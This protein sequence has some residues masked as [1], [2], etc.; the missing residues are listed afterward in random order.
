[1]LWRHGGV[2]SSY[3]APPDP[4]KEQEHYD[5]VLTPVIMAPRKSC[6]FMCPSPPRGRGRMIRP[7]QTTIIGNNMSIKTRHGGREGGSFFHT[8]PYDDISLY[9]PHPSI[10][11]S[12][13]G[14][15]CA[16]RQ[17][18]VD[19]FL[20]SESGEFVDVA[21]LGILTQLTSGTG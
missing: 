4:P 15:Q 5:Y 12:R 19:V 20:A 10:H 21:T 14:D 1:M 7:S 9:H 6:P 11:R 16:A 8:P 18:S 3:S 13:L 17:I 2:A